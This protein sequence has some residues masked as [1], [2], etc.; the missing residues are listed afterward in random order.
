MRYKKIIAYSLIAGL[1]LLIIAFPYIIPM[2]HSERIK[3]V[4][5]SKIS[6]IP[7]LTTTQ[8]PS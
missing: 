4:D 2:N 3:L 6:I 8:T 1:V 5:G 7:I